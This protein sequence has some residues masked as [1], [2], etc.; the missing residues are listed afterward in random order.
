M[1]TNRLYEILDETTVQLRKGEAVREK[2]HEGFTVI[3]V[4][5][6]PHVSQLN[7]ERFEC[8]DVHFIV[9]GVNKE[10]AMK[11][12]D[13]VIAILKTYP[14][15]ERFRQGLSYIEVG[16]VIGDQGAALQLFALGE[17]IG[18]WHIITPEKLGMKGAAETLAGN[19]FIMNDGFKE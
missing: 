4:Q 3:T 10:L 18:L 7:D 8:I 19:G 15:L 11:Y 2:K 6:M 9:V 1:E 14:N 13:E 16:A 5:A 12:R 17:A